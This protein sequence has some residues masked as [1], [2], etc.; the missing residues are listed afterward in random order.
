MTTLWPYGLFPFNS[1]DKMTP[2]IPVVW[3]A[4]FTATNWRQTHNAISLYLTS[5]VVELIVE[6]S[7]R[8]TTIG[9][10][11]CTKTS[12]KRTFLNIRNQFRKTEILNI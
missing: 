5:Y 7:N 1:A 4:R 12:Q 8:L 3:E 2:V 10:S 6:N 9:K 11:K